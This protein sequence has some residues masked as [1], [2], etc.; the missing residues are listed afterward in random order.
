MAE[1][2]FYFNRRALE[3]DFEQRVCVVV[4][5]SDPFHACIDFEVDPC[6][7][8]GCFG[9]FVDLFELVY[10]GCGES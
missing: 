4:V 6:N 1:N 9:C 3:S 2:S 8:F 10:R 7:G 5:N